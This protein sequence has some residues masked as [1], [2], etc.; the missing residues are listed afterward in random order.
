[1][2]LAFNAINSGL[3]NNGGSR[4]ILKCARVL[5]DLGHECDVIAGSDNFTWF[6]HKPTIKH[7]PKDLDALV[8]VAAVDL[9]S[10]L[11]VKTE[12]VKAWYIRAHETWANSEEQLINFYN[13]QEI[14][15]IVNSNG[16]RKQLAS[17]GAE[18]VVVYQGLD[19]DLWY[20][21]NRRPANK[22]RIGCL[23]T[24]QPRKRWK[25][26]VKLKD[27]LGTK[28]YEY[29]GMGNAVPKVDFLADFKH[30]VG[31]DELRKL[32]SSCHIWFAPTESEGLHNPPMEASLCGALLVCS[33]HTLNGM[34]HDYAHD[35]SAM[36]Y[37]AGN[38]KQAAELI[39]NPDYN[40]VL[41]M[42]SVLVTY[43]G[44]REEN[45]MRLAEELND[46][47]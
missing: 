2:K 17:Y 8:N 43:I 45:M 29:V 15:N 20:D 32:Y 18:S 5:E 34:I 31:P 14:L 24:K 41:D 47:Y 13:E 6:D 22:I 35:E 44:S 36:I 25:D 4:T 12:L 30:N 28:D 9:P 3:G 38:I 46:N 7:L 11:Y 10:T 37:E 33:N 42:Q 27:I 19:F 21:E 1:M 40:K 39:R 26:F 23:Y 16:L